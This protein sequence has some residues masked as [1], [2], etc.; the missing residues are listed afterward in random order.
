MCVW[1]SMKPGETINPSAFMVRCAGARMR[2]ISTMRPSD[3]PTSARYRPM[4]D[5]STMVPFLITRSKVMAWSSLGFPSPDATSPS[6][7][8]HLGNIASSG[9]YRVTWA[10]LR[11]LGL[12]LC[13]VPNMRSLLVVLLVCCVIKPSAAADQSSLYQAMEIV[14]GTDMRERPRGFALCL[15]DVLVKVSGDPRLRADPRVTALAPHAADYVASFNYVDPIAGTRPHDDQGTY[16][17]FGEPDRRLRPGEDRR[18]AG[19]ARRTAVA[20]ATAG[21]G[22]GAVGARPRTAGLSVER[23]RTPRRGATRR[24]RTHRRRDRDRAAHSVGVRIHRSCGPATRLH[25]AA[26]A[27]RTSSSSARS[28]GVR[29]RRD[30]S[31][32]GVPAGEV[33]NTSGPIQAAATTWRSRTSC[34]ARC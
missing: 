31:A 16:R 28:I 13:C 32:R 14:T 15:A 8:R 19:F 9:Q 20:R 12:R 4:P 6:I 24:L 25:R 22:S 27:D 3:T 23:R 5:P 18:A 34:K 26:P 30:G 1:P 11:H 10:I 21:A 2:P 33:A 29:Q 17:P 7:S